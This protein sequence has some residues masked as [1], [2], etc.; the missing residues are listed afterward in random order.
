[1]TAKVLGRY[2]GIAK[3]ATAVIL[4]M[5]YLENAMAATI[6]KQTTV[7]REKYLESLLNAAD[8]IATK[9]RSGK[10]VVNMSFGMPGKYA[11]PKF[12]DMMRK[13]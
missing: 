2:L 12:F 4:D 5:T 6:S 10:A 8:D 13:S 9:K 11:P 1:V 3:E 7:V